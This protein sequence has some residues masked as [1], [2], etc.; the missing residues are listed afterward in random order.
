MQKL[1]QAYFF[2][3]YEESALGLQEDYYVTGN[4]QKLHIS[5]AIP[6]L[7]LNTKPRTSKSQ[8]FHIL[9]KEAFP[10]LQ[11]ASMSLLSKNYSRRWFRGFSVFL[12]NRKDEVIAHNSTIVFSTPLLGIHTKRS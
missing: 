10:A 11:A 5:R 8:E 2:N 12:G 6:V 9:L 4:H 1:H 7:A 3:H